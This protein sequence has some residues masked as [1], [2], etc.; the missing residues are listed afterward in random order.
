MSSVYDQRTV[1][2]GDEFALITTAEAKQD[3]PY[4]TAQPGVLLSMGC[5][6]F[7]QLGDNS[8]RNQW[9]PKELNKNAAQM[10]VQSPATEPPTSFLLGRD[11]QLL[12][13]GKYHSVAV[14]LYVGLVHNDARSI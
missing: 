2:C 3:N 4:N 5:N 14:T 1:A 11:I 10:T 8:G 13:C 7:G 9:V 12:A 6:N